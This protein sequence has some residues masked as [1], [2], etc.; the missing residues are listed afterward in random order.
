MAINPR[1]VDRYIEHRTWLMRYENRV[2]RDVLGVMLRGEEQALGAIAAAYEDFREA[3]GQNAVWSNRGVMFRKKALNRTRAALQDVFPEARKSLRDALE[4]VA[5]AENE[6]FGQT[7]A[8]LM[9][10]PAVNELE[11][12]RV[13]ERQIANLLDD[14]FGERLEGSAAQ[15][16]DGLKEIED[17]TL[18]RLNQT[19][20]DGVRDGAGTRDMIS[21]ARKVVG[22]GRGSQLSRD[23]A[24]YVRTA[25]QTTAND[26]AGQ[27]YR[28]N[29]DLVRGEQFV[30]TLDKDTCPICGPL[31]G[32][33]FRL[34]AKGTGSIPRPPR[35]PNCRCF[36]APV[37]KRWDEMGLP[38]SLPQRAKDLLNGKPA[39][40]TTWSDWVQRNPDRL[41][42][43]L[44]PSRAK[45]V[46]SG[47]FDLSDLATDTEV[48]PLYGDG[49]RDNPAKG[50]LLY[51][52]KRRRGAA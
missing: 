10:E 6:V 25:V 51:R 48:I 21:R 8:E 52:A 33:V 32:K 29:D 20:A 1:I 13:P 42:D 39:K 19:L 41:E 9:P 28:E 16:A 49:T 35:H 31:D 5:L 46:R 3:G 47:K 34:D 23:I 30:A 27:V 11:F 12:S 22:A 50:S 7:M 45:L 40:R 2:A 44:G 18:T 14:K 38:D 37:L 24:T 17:R 26:V 36:V 15:Y 43:V 4:G